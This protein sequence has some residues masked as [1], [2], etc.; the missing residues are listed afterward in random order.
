MVIFENRGG[1]LKIPVEIKEPP[2]KETTVKELQQL[3]GFVLAGGCSKR[4]KQVA[5]MIRK[6][7]DYRWVGI[8]KVTKKEFVIMAASDEE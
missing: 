6:A 3:G 7:R 8:Y 4:M 5:Q 1:V 2:M